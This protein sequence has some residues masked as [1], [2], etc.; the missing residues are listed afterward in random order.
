MFYEIIKKEIYFVVSHRAS[1]VIQLVK[2]YWT[3]L[4]DIDRDHISESRPKVF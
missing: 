3:P 1:S 4:D 2:T